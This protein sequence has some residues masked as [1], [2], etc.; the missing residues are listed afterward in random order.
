M[1]RSNKAAYPRLQKRLELIVEALLWRFRLIAIVPVVMSLASSLLSFAIGTKDIYHSLSIFFGANVY[2][3]KESVVLAGVVSGIDFYLIGVALLIFG[4]GMYEL[5]ISELDVYRDQSDSP[6][7]GGLLDIRSLDQLKEK[8]VK[9]LVVALIVSGFKSMISLPIENGDSMIKFCLG[10]LLLA[11]SGFLIT[12]KP[13][14]H[15]S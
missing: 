9:V 2:H 3:V 15:Q 1:S 5:L 10:V 4:Y 12:F 8:L 11:I 7:G 13:G 6:D 14:K